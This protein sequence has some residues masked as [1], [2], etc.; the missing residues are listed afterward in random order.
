MLVDC[1]WALTWGSESG[2]ASCRSVVFCRRCGPAYG[3]A[4]AGKLDRL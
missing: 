1:G 3:D 2:M 4:A